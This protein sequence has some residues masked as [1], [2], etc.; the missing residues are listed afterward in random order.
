MVSVQEAQDVV[1]QQERYEKLVQKQQRKKRKESEEDEE[2]KHVDDEGT[3]TSH[4]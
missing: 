2:L 1:V 3:H 4:A